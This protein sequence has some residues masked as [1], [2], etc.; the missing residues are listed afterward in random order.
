MVIAYFPSTTTFLQAWSD[1][2][3]VRDAYPLRNKMLEGDFKHIWLR[4]H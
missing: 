3:L 2:K 4:C 1:P